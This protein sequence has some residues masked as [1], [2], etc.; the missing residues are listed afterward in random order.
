MAKKTE[1]PDLPEGAAPGTDESPAPAKKGK[2]IPKIAIIAGIV[3]IQ[4]VAAYFIQ[5]TLFFS[6]VTAAV[7]E[8]KD[9]SHKAEKKGGHGEEDSES[10]VVMLDEI[11][12]NPAHTSGRRYLAITVGFQTSAL[13]AEKLFE[14]HKPIIRDGLITLLSTK[15][16]EQLANIAY[17]DTLK[18]EIKESVNKLV[19][20]AAVT[21]VVF[22]SYVLQ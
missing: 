3:V 17:R 19:K 7:E 9:E 12:V 4:I 8:K 5:K 6:D 15:E 13:E 20:D 22:S 14:K 11:I 1:Q 10:A 2:G 18:T 16:M 21:N